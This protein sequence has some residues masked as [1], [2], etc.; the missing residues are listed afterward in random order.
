MARILENPLYMFSVYL[1]ALVGFAAADSYY[2]SWYGVP[3]A[4]VAFL[5]IIILLTYTLKTNYG[6]M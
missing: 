3:A 4:A 5:T 6:G 1:S 2:G